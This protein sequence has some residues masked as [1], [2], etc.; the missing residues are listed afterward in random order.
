MINHLVIGSVGTLTNTFDMGHWTSQQLKSLGAE[1]S[2]GGSHANRYH[3][4]GNDRVYTREIM[5]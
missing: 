3:R 4:R 2:G 1:N 5:G